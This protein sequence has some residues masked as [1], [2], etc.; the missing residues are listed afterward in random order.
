MCGDSNQI[1]HPN[2]FSWSGLK[3]MFYEQRLGSGNRAR[4]IT[5]VLVNNYRNFR[6][7][8][9]LANRLLMVKN[10][11]FGS[12]DRESNYLVTCVAKHDGAVELLPN[13]DRV[14][15]DID[16]KTSRSMRTAVL[17][18]RDDDKAEAAT[19]FST[20]LLF[21][22][23]EDRSLRRGFPKQAEPDAVDAGQPPWK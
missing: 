3:S 21:S 6:N 14:L 4:Q 17:V 2:F 11:R 23:Q 13:H 7:V 19:R 10:A 16:T 15:R 8:T 22:I 12:I 20:P 1:V 5:R 18:P 9:A